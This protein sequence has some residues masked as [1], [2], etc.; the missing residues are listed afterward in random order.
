MLRVGRWGEGFCAKLVSKSGA[1]ARGGKILESGA[2]QEPGRE[3]G[4]RRQA[5][6]PLRKND[7]GKAK[8][9]KAK[10]FAERILHRSQPQFA[11]TA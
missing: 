6:P 11:G 4:S 3:G 8:A 1:R 5:P 7:D 10:N 2:M 9:K